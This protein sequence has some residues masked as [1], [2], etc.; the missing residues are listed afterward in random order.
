MKIQNG[1]NRD[2]HG[3]ACGHISHLSFKLAL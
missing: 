2:F 3:K 1:K